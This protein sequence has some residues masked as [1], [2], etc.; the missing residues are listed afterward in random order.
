MFV[1]LDWPINVLRRF[2]SISWASCFYRPD[3][4]HGAQPTVSKHSM[5]LLTPISPGGLPTLSLFRPTESYLHS[6]WVSEG[7]TTNWCTGFPSCSMLYSEYT[8]MM[9]TSGSHS[10]SLIQTDHL[11]KPRWSV[12]GCGGWGLAMGVWPCQSPVSLCQLTGNIM[13]CLQC[14][15]TVGWAIGRVCGL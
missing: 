6:Q 8:T 10:A 5:N 3:A 2:V 12:C 4:L 14:F 11:G 7:C 15:D 1:D 9:G 13:I